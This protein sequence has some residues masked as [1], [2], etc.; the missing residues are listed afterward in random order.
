MQRVLVFLVVPPPQKPFR[1]VLKS[2]DDELFRDAKSV[3]L[4]M[5]NV[6]KIPPNRIMMRL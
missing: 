1:A 6:S 2:H 5:N 3:K 4:H